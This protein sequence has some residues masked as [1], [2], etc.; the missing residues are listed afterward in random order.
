ML[1]ILK[2]LGALVTQADAFMGP[3]LCEVFAEQGAEVVASAEPLAEPAAPQQ[4]VEA[5]GRIDV[6]VAN[7]ALHA[8]STPALQVAHCEGGRLRL[9]ASLLPALAQE[10]RLPVE[11]LLGQPSS[12]KAAAKRGPAPK[13]A[14][15]MERISAQP[16]TQHK[17]VPQM[18]ETDLAQQGR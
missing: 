3:A 5:A 6:L 13:L 7:L 10:L 16:R 18:I 11:A 17:F 1:D 2:G 9:R 8:P 4:V 15:H 12:A 14:R